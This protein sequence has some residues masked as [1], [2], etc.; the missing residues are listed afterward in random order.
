MDNCPL[1]RNPDQRDSDGDGVGDACDNCPNIRNSMQNDLDQ[2]QV[3]DSC[4]TGIDGDG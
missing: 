3:G 4:D 1:R 2:D